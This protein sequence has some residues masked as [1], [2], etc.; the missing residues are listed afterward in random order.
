MHE[1]DLTARMTDL[2]MKFSFLEEHVSQQ[3]REMLKLRNLLDRQT[4]ALDRLRETQGGD[5][6]QV[7]GD[8]RP[9]HY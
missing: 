7:R 9:P 8:E 5:S 6:F 1:P 2:E 4:E 3:D